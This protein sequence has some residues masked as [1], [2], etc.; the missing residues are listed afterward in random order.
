VVP[1]W[2]HVL[3]VAC[4]VLGG[5]CALTIAADLL[6][7]P[8]RMWIMNVVWPV[9]ALF[10]LGWIVW[11]YF[12]YARQAQRPTPRGRQ[13]AKPRPPP[14]PFAVAVS[15]ATLHCGSACTLGDILA[16]SLLAAAPALAVWLG[17]PRLF[18]ERMYAA[19]IL[20]YLFAFGLGIVF[21]YFAIAPARGLSLAAG[22]AA[23]IKADALSLSAW[24]LGMYSAM[25]LASALFAALTP[26]GLTAG[27][28]EFWLS[29]QVAMNAGFI[30]AYPVNWWLLRR[31]I[32][33]PM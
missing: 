29:M 8:Q 5:V 2:L 22:L 30:T 23:A 28:P 16:E 21:Q 13:T 31:G 24:Q 26:S 12:R 9:C 32:K 11:L 18:H 20:D 7:H 15:S 3:S 33:A 19:W 27:R 14:A 6:R 25:A 10:G 1:S 4:L 17:W